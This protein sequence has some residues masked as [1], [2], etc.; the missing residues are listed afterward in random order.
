[1]QGTCHVASA[2]GSLGLLT[3]NFTA[4]NTGHISPIY[5]SLTLLQHT[6]ESSTF[7]PRFKSRF[8]SRT[9]HTFGDTTFTSFS[10]GNIFGGYKTFEILR[11]SMHSTRNGRNAD[12]RSNAN[13]RAHD[14]QQTNQHNSPSIIA[15]SGAR[16]GNQIE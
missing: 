9:L 5:L 15:I 13:E 14:K 12:D 1:M 2:F 3:A 8:T 7:H 4:L 16:A 6:Y 10:Y 11:S